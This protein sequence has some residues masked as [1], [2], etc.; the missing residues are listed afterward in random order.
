MQSA[1]FND[2]SSPVVVLLW[3]ACQAK[4]LVREGTSQGMGSI[5]LA[6]TSEMSISGNALKGPQVAKGLVEDASPVKVPSL[7][8]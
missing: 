5:L 7:A 8:P 3:P 4:L 1:V 2:M 6:P